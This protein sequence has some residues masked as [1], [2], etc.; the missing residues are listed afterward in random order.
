MSLKLNVSKWMAVAALSGLLPWQAAGQSAIAPQGTEYPIVGRLAGDQTKPQLAIGPSGG[1]LVWQDNATDGDGLGVSAR[2]L[3]SNLTPS[4]GAVRVNVNGVGDQENPQ[5]A[6]LPNGGAV[7]VWQGGKQGFQKVYARFMT[8]ANV[9]VAGDVAVSSY[10]GQQINPVVAGLPDGSVVI[11]WASFGQDGDMQG[12]FAQRFSSLG[13]KLGTEFQVNQTTDL[14]QRTPAIAV[15]DKGWFLLAWVSEQSKGADNNGGTQYAVDIFARLYAVNASPAGDEFKLNAGTNVCAN[16][17]IMSLPQGGF[18]AAWSENFGIAETNE[19]LFTN[20]W[21]VVSRTFDA[22]G[23]PASAPVRVNTTAFGDQYAPRVAP[24]Q[25][26]GLMVWTSMGQDGSWEG[27]YGRSLTVAGIPEGDE[28]LINNTTASRQ[29]HA[30]VGSDAANRFLVCWTSFTGGLESFDLFA[31]Q[32]SAS[33]A[34]VQPDPPFVSALPQSRL[35]VTWPA[36]SGLEVANYE[37]YLDDATTPVATTNNLVNLGP[38]LA[39]STHSVRLLYELKDGSRSPKSDAA[40]VAT[41]GDDA[42]YDGLPDDWQAK[43]WGSDP[44][45]WPGANVD[46]DGDGATNLQEFLA[47]TDP[48]DPNSVLK[49]KLIKPQSQL[50]G[51]SLEWNTE[52][53]FIYQVQKSTNI[54]VWENVDAPRLAAEDR[55][56]LPL[57]GEPGPVNYYRVIRLR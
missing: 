47:G 16:P 19:I 29:M 5:V 4:F 55:D 54:N 30:T 39:G 41:W 34:L 21:E 12:V 46:S 6:L 28:F 50:Q 40:L 3:N 31:R 22:T 8:S 17:S 7:F 38:L 13:A 32:Y 51:W 36:L 18:V 25:S 35:S 27:V 44:S 26:G 24:G 48:T 2:R 45:K 42:N 53:G 9:F 33:K 15:L 37:V 52:R 11:S 23:N 1:F 49:I 43:Y 20:G 14:N 56:S 57:S 10:A